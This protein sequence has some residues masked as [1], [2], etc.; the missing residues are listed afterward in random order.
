MIGLKQ[1]R[2]C[3]IGELIEIEDVEIKK[4]LVFV[5]TEESKEQNCQ[6]VRFIPGLF[7]QFHSRIFLVYHRKQCG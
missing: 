3:V 6:P 7:D 2:A 1:V 5:K 4:K